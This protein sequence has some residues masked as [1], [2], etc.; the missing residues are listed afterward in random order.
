[1]G[2]CGCNKSN[3]TE[4][5]FFDHFWNKIQIKNLTAEQLV[6]KT[7][8]LK[9]KTTKEDFFKDFEEKLLDI[10]F[11]CEEPK[12]VTVYLIHNS[13]SMVSGFKAS[14][15]FFSLLLICDCKSEKSFAEAFKRFIQLCSKFEEVSALNFNDKYLIREFVIFYVYLVS[16]QTHKAFLQTP[17]LLNVFEKSR[18]E[19]NSIY[20]Q[21]NRDV[22]VEGLFSYYARNEF[23][24][25]S[26]AL[27]N[28]KKLE[29]SNVR[30]SLEEI[31]RKNVAKFVGK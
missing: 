22:F 21:K 9:S 31:E 11:T 18:S 23:T 2:A 8:Q 13:L 5:E 15:V 3:S 14:A 1:M 24:L 17:N 19:F 20:S 30:K 7:L 26:F 4:E 27:E 16:A 10:Y 25:F 12:S 28:L 29:H 6:E